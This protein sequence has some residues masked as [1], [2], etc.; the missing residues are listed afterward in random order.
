MLERETNNEKATLCE[1]DIITTYARKRNE[2]AITL[3]RARS[4]VFAYVEAVHSGCVGLIEWP[5]LLPFLIATF[6]ESED[7]S[8]K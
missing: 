4:Q 1:I 2:K 6:G 5:E 3:T 8:K 7:S